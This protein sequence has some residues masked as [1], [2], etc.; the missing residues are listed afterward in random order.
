MCGLQRGVSSHLEC[1]PKQ[2]PT[3]SVELWS[4]PVG[5]KSSAAARPEVLQS[6]AIHYQC[7]FG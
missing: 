5:V 1:D 7:C 3:L 6:R 2:F 4:D